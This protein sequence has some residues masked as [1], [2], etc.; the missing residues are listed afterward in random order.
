MRV[1]EVATPGES[2]RQQ[3]PATVRL[4]VC[5]YHGGVELSNSKEVGGS[6]EGF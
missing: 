3:R 4:I 6:P 2:H 1:K 5:K